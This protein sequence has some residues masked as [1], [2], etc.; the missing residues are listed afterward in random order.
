MDQ[1]VECEWVR[2]EGGTEEEEK[3]EDCGLALVVAEGQYLPIDSIGRKL[4]GVKNCC[5]C[6]S[7][8]CGYYPN[9]LICISL[10]SN[11]YFIK[12]FILY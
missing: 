3:G 5:G 6:G 11:L 8:V 10:L 4:R 1:W 9:I 7:V 2:D 12:R